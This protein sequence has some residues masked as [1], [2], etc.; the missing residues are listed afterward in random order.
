M[1][2][3]YAP[4]IND[5][6]TDSAQAFYGLCLTVGIKDFILFG[7]NY[8]TEFLPPSPC[9]VIWDKKNSGNFADVE[10]ACLQGIQVTQSIGTRDPAVKSEKYGEIAWSYFQVGASASGAAGAAIMTPNITSI[11]QPYRR[12]S[13]SA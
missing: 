11:L 8:F 6:S 5:D 1:P 7:G 10:M 9:W 13:R 12:V 2:K 4:I 3:L